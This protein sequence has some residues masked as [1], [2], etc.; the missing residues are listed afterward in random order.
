M[1]EYIC[2]KCNRTFYRKF[3]FDQH[4]KRK[5]D[6]SGDLNGSKTNKKID[7]KC[8]KCKK[9]FS[10]KDS[11][12][13]HLKICKGNI[14]K[15]KGNDNV[16]MNG[17][18]N[19][20]GNINGNDNI[21]NINSSNS[22]ITVNKDNMNLNIIL[23]NYPPDKYSFVKDI[24]KI[25]SSD[26]NLILEIIKKT[27]VNK[28]KPQYHNIYYPDDKKSNG[29]IYNNN[30]WNIKQ[31][32]EIVNLM[33][34][35]NVDYLKE[36]LDEMGILFDDKIKNKIMKSCQQFYDTDARKFL[37]KNIKMLLF[38]NRDMVKKTKTIAKYI[39]NDDTDEEK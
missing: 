25:L 37:R 17:N 4:K 13:R 27:N 26:N 9:N 24:G 7:H 36:Y 21:K 33:I 10:R 20:N 11:L 3:L 6:C 12:D 32:D 1:V 39:P 31:I 38:A 18:E 30:K 8:K 14:T 16:N 15:I 35:K 22:K 29:E 2:K 34:E 19:I 28:N 23:L 5:T